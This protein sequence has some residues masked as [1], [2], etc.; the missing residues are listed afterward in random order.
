M[1]HP[2]PGSAHDI[3]W[4]LPHALHLRVGNFMLQIS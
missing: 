2:L 1:H 3:D 4:L